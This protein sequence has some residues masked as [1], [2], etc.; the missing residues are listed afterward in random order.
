MKAVTYTIK[1]N[2]NALSST[3]KLILNTI[4]LEHLI[5]E[6][7]QFEIK[8][9]LNE[10]IVNALCHGN[11]CE[12]E[13]VTYVTFRLLNNEYLY[14]SVKD[15]GCGFNKKIDINSVD[16]YLKITNDSLC[17]HG[18]GLIIVNKICDKVKYNKLG[19]KVSVIYRMS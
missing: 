9:V 17:E 19:N 8:V 6:Q 3:I 15:E 10:L 11:N 12:K 4:S 18:R 13:K 14:I 7:A 2:I 16:D 5:S 1:Q